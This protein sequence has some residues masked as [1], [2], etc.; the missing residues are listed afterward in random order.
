MTRNNA[1]ER[2]RGVQAGP[3]GL[4]LPD[5]TGSQMSPIS[6]IVM[7]AE[8]EEIMATGLCYLFLDDWKGNSYERLD[9]GKHP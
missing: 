7:S 2:A 8:R 9:S 6:I 4:R 1:G 3:C 5:R